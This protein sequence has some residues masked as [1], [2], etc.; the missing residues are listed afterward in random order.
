MRGF[1]TFTKKE[2]TELFRSYRAVLLGIVSFIL[3]IMNPLIA[4]LTPWLM[5]QMSTQ[6]EDQGIIIGEIKVTANDSW[7]QFSKNFPMLLIV[8]IIIFCGSYV[9]EYSRGTLIPL[10]TKGL[11]RTSVV[12]SKLLMQIITWTTCHV[13]YSGITWGYTEYYWKGTPAKEVLFVA[14]CLWLMGVYILTLMTCLSAF[15]SS[16]MQ[17]L[18]G[19]GIVYFAL[20][21]TGMIGSA[22]K[23]VPTWLLNSGE[24]FRGK[25]EMG[26]FATAMI[27]AAGF[28]I[29]FVI[30]AIVQTK[31]RKL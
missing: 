2:I 26:D 3:A 31:K 14:F 9:K 30:V 29:L 23:L 27:I 28:S 22:K 8:V 17:V 5:E 10:L 19:V 25:S 12:I 24:V 15:M 11:S 6:L 21:M 4:K 7:D 18:L 1:G 20:T 16:S 13:I